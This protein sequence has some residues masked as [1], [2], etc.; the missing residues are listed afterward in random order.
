MIKSLLKSVLDLQKRNTI[1]SLTDHC[2]TCKQKGLEG[3][4][5]FMVVLRNK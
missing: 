2:I 5:F 4:N 1:H 3:L